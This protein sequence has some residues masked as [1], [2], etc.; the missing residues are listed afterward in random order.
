MNAY[1]H[2]E[3]VLSQQT[4][5]R[6]S[7]YFSEGFKMWK[8]HAKTFIVFTIIFGLSQALLTSLP[9]GDMGNELWFKHAVG[10]GGILVS[11]RIY[12]GEHYVNRDFLEGFK[13]S[14]QIIV[15][16][17]LMVGIILVLCL[18]ILLAIGVGSLVQF[19]DF[20]FSVPIELL[21]GLGIWMSLLIIPIIY[22]LLLF[23]YVDCFIAFYGLSALEAI[24]YSAKFVHRHWLS[25]F[26]FFFLVV[27]MVVAG[28][29]GFIIGIVVTI[30]M[31]Y[32]I[33]FYSFQDMTQLPEFEDVELALTEDR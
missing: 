7:E 8:E 4:V 26:G 11:H 20:P 10:L 25:V 1:D 27:L 13:F 32:P 33:V 5:F 6:T 16:H 29:L 21:A 3:D 14:A 12:M 30:S 9:L 31:V 28:L 15:A 18:P 17:L 22:V 23:A 19:A 2:L 24:K